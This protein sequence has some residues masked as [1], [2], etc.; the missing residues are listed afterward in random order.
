MTTIVY[1]DGEF[2]W[3]TQT[4]WIHGGHTGDSKVFRNGPVVFGVSG[5]SRASD[6]LQYMEVPSL[7][8]YE[9]DFDVN[10]WVVRDLI[11]AIRKEF[12]DEKFTPGEK[13]FNTDSHVLL[14]APGVAGYLASDLSWVQDERGVLAVGSGSKY[15]IGALEHGATPR[16]AVKTAMKWD[17]YTGGSVEWMKV[18]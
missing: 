17:V 7:R 4:T 8:D 9:P 10:R 5:R 14:W 15:A 13:E 11:P 12:E 6:L 1:K 2:A 16:E 18:K 3:D